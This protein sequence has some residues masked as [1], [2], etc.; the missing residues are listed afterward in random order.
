MSHNFRKDYAP[1]ISTLT[2]HKT[3]RYTF[4][5][6]INAA[7][8]LRN[9]AEFFNPLAAE[10][11]GNHLKSPVRS[12]TDLG[13][14]PG[15]TAQMLATVTMAENVTGLDI[16]DH[17]ISLAK[18]QYPEI[19]FVKQDLT[20]WDSA[21]KYNVLYGRF[22]L[23][24]LVNR[25]QLLS[26]WIKHLEPGGLLFI[27]ELEDIYT[28]IPVFQ[29]YLKMNELLIKSQG[30]ELFVGKLLTHEIRKFRVV[31]NQSDI[32]PV[33]DFQASGWSY[34]NTVGIWNEEEIVLNT[35]TANERKAISEVLL[36]IYKRG[37]NQSNITWKM[38]RIILTN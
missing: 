11:I 37:K 38:K 29:K 12:A 22:L 9:I 34:P 28:D 13:C 6:T 16:S 7:E 33:L 18:K 5:H 20:Q 36:E 8:R 24:H 31:L 32:I 35:L 1:Q 26:N 19:H 30:A 17:F 4:G 23:S 21:E 25:E 27:D 10:F 2:T 15:Y 14:G 3:M